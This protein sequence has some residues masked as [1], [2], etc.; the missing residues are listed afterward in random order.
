M[1]LPFMSAPSEPGLNAFLGA[2][3]LHV[4][5]QAVSFPLFHPFLSIHVSC[6]FM[7][8]KRYKSTLTVNMTALIL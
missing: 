4:Y 1:L 6:L 8:I 2:P 5:K 3:Q 7:V